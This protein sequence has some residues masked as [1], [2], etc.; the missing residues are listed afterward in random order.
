M[1]GVA[2]AGRFYR[3]GNWIFWNIRKGE[4]AITIDVDH[5]GYVSLV[6]EVED[7]EK[8]LREIREAIAKAQ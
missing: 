8:T 1:P 4:K 2:I 7:P 5:E 6:V 3:H